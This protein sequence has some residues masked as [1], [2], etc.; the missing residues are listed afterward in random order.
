MSWLVEAIA[1]NSLIVVTDGSFMKEIYLYI[2]LAAFV[3]ECTKGRG[4]LWG[5]FVEHSPDAG[6]Y[7]GEL[8]GLM[9]IH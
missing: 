8:L 1:D 7:R 2:N 3:F 6:S 5:S 9:V 4:R